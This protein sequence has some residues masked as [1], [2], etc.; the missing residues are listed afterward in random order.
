MEPRSHI[1]V[2][3]DEATQ[4]QLLVD[5]LTR[6]NFR[7]TGVDGGIAL[8][9]LFERELPALVLLDVGLPDEDGF[10]IARWLRERTARVGIIMVT[11][12][13][14]TVDRVIG[15]EIGA[16][17]YIA[18]PFEPRELLARVKSVL[19]RTINAAPPSAGRAF[20]WAAGYWISRSEARENTASRSA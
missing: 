5:Y 15:L 19:R 20:A 4:R 3:E 18:K 9:K 1:V 10:T 8:R 7:V 11:V 16:D 6:Q 17:D 2:V 13:S 12:A 14:D